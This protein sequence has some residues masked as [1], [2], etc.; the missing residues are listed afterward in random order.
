MGEKLYDL[1]DKLAK[2]EQE[3][4][5]AGGEITDE[6]ER[7]L[8]EANL[9]IRD[10]AEGIGKWMLNLDGDV[11]AIDKEI[12]RLTARKKTRV[13]LQARLMEYLKAAMDHAEIHKLDCGT[14]SITIQKNPASVEI[15]DGEKIP[16]KYLTIIPQTTKVNKV[17]VLK[18]LKKGDE[19]V[20]ARLINDKTHLRLR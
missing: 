10:K 3:I 17:E 6:I 1:T 2:V 20:G 18:D 8:D 7:R 9:A 19:V 11:E 4:L 12:A 15:T 5:L 14:F 16:T 13:N